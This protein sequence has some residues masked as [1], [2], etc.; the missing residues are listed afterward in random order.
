MSFK[1]AECYENIQCLTTCHKEKTNISGICQKN[2]KSKKVIVI[3]WTNYKQKQLISIY[4]NKNG[5]I[6]ACILACIMYFFT[7]IAYLKK[8]L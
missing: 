2:L 3:Y 6:T 8:T 1:L 7:I 4:N 5:L